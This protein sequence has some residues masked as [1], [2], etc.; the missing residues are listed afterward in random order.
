MYV[1]GINC[2]FYCGFVQ[3]GCAIHFLAV[4][5]VFV[6]MWSHAVLWLGVRNR[7]DRHT[8]RFSI[9]GSVRPGNRARLI[10][11]SRSPPATHRSGS[12]PSC[13]TATL[14]RTT[15][16]APSGTH[17]R[18]RRSTTATSLRLL[19]EQAQSF[20][21]IGYLATATRFSVFPGALGPEM[22]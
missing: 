13:T 16:R 9:S 6:G 3:H 4:L 12:G 20:H 14:S 19:N 15:R 17:T 21:M 1:L 11:Q 18:C 2:P 10:A 22:F 8:K 7:V 5:S